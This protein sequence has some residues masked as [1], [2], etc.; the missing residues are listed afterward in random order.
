[1]ELRQLERT[2]AALKADYTNLLETHA[3]EM[4]AAHQNVEKLRAEFAAEKMIL[5]ERI[6]KLP[7]VAQED[8]SLRVQE[9][10]S[11]VGH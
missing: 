9:T 1:L 5:L 6:S 2:H 4:Q 10:Q 8:R 3:E 11:Q 7:N